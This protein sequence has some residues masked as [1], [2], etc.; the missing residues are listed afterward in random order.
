M[1]NV[2][3]H[4]V[5]A[6]RVLDSWAHRPSEAPF[7]PGRAR[8]RDAFYQGAFGPDLG[9]FPG[10]NPFLSDLAHYVRSGD[11]VRA[12]LRRAEGPVQSAF[13]WGWLTHVLADQA[14]HPLVGEGVGELLHGTRRFVGISENATAHV[15]VEVGLDM[16][17]ASR[18]PDLSSLPCRPVFDRRSVRHLV[19]AYRETYALEVDPDLFLSSHHAAVR[20]ARRALTTIGVLSLAVGAGNGFHGAL[21]TR[22]ILRRTLALV[23]EGLDRESMI[24]AFLNPVPPADWL[25]GEVEAVVESFPERF[26]RW[27]PDGV[28]RLPDYN[29]DTGRVEEGGVSTPCGAG[30]VRILDDLGAAGFPAPEEGRRPVRYPG[31]PR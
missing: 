26:R 17:Y 10:G 18:H 2:T 12:L 19:G 3:L 6:G 11:L 7:D 20:M 4:A 22:R 25:R 21:G 31:C 24:L 5:L 27:C 30:A 1:P 16:W 23:Q 9:Y 8:L 28:S 15:R 14:I 13:A 29:L